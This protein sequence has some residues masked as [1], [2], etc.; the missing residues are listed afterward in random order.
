MCLLWGI[1]AVMGNR[2][3]APAVL[4][5]L[6]LTFVMLSQAVI[7][8]AGRA[9]V[10]GRRMAA[11]AIT[12]LFVLSFAMLLRVTYAGVVFEGGTASPPKHG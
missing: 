6:P 9:E 11:L 5:L 2:G 3:K 8:W 7:V 10:P 4:T 1:R 12:G